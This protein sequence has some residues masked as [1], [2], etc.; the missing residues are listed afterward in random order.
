MS[1]D[2]AE[3][4]ESDL[5]SALLADR[6]AES[7]SAA[8]SSPPKT[9]LADNSIVIDAF[10]RMGSAPYRVEWH[11][12]IVYGGRHGGLSPM[13]VVILRQFAEEHGSSSRKAPYRSVTVPVAFLRLIR[14][15]DIWQ[16]GVRVGSDS[17]SLR[18][19]FDNLL[20]DEA[21]TAT[22]PIGLPMCDDGAQ[23]AYL[24]PFSKFDGHSNHTGSA[25]VKV[26]VDSTTVLVI[27]CMELIRF[28]FGQSGMLLKT[29]FSGDFDSRRLY[30][31]FRHDCDT[32]ISYLS[33]ADE[34]P[35]SAAIAVARF[36][37]DDRAKY[38][39]RWIAKSGTAA[40]ANS[41]PYYPKTTFPF[42]GRTSLTVSGR[43]IQESPRRVFLVEQLLRCTNPFPFRELRV[44]ETLAT[45]GGQSAPGART[46]GRAG[47]GRRKKNQQQNAPLSEGY[48]DP[49]LAPKIIQVAEEVD[50]PFPDLVG[51]PI[52]RFVS[53]ST[54]ASQGGKAVDD[55][56]GLSSGQRSSRLGG[57]EVEVV[58]YDRSAVLRVPE[59]ELVFRFR[60]EFQVLKRRGLISATLAPP[61]SGDEGV[62][63]NCPFVR[64]DWIVRTPTP[65]AEDT[66]C[67]RILS[68]IT[69][70]FEEPSEENL[71]VLIR[72]NPA[73][74]DVDQ[75]VL[76][77]WEYSRELTDDGVREIC[78]SFAEYGSTPSEL[79]GDI[80]LLS[81]SEAAQEN[82]LGLLILAGL[83]S[84]SEE[85]AL[86]SLK[87]L[88]A[89]NDHPKAPEDDCA[90]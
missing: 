36:A 46:P 29:L 38:A 15:G 8:I 23:P 24:L 78:E 56:C 33:L 60:E 1:D 14:I 45:K 83:A 55:D 82:A 88:P 37:F 18:L 27:P 86:A 40:G 21:T 32:G 48:V 10:R 87:S 66:W 41:E 9:S 53:A 26:Q 89:G 73:S 52:R 7:R 77:R 69:A 63:G 71:M 57:R 19:T 31:F 25:C 30:R 61:L 58:D 5:A 68:S 11:G 35:Y 75:I 76:T 74:D 72:E 51:K 67:A 39:M 42:I 80:Q 13:V 12:D 90:A 2:R 28:Y 81:Q 50:H 59:P 44:D 17:S 62:F 4:T 16:G 64:C 85:E 47:S 65:V 79:C 43:W 22:Q 84:M 49:G 70:P 20:I 34:M 54:G 6:P 3:L